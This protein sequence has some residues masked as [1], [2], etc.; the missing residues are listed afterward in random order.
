ML[1]DKVLECTQML[2]EAKNLQED[3]LSVERYKSTVNKMIAETNSFCNL[4]EVVQ[5]INKTDYCKIVFTE[6]DIETIKSEINNCGL[7]CK[8]KELKDEHIIKFNSLIMK[9][10][11]FVEA[12]WKQDASKYASSIEGYLRVLMPLIQNKIEAQLVLNAISTGKVSAPTVLGVEKFT[13]SVKKAHGL[14]DGYKLT[15]DV[16]GFIKKVKEGKASYA[17]LTPE[18]I[19]WIKEVGI[20]N[21]LKISF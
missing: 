14:A 3:K 20:E 7:A 1:I 4:V 11:M 8:K 13:E 21:K 15:P 2:E 16:E 6:D 17:D 9:Y 12:M 18:V 19:G 5:S 10:T